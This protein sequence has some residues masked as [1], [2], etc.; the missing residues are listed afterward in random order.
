MRRSVIITVVSVA[1]LFC[2]TVTSF[3]AED[4]NPQ[5]PVRVELTL[6]EAINSALKNSFSIRQA[7]LDVDRAEKVRDAAWEYHG[8]MLTKTWVETEQAFVS[9]PGMD[10]MSLFQA[11]SADRAAHIQKKTFE[12][13]QDAI[14][15]QVTQA[16][17]DIHKKLEDLDTAR[18]ALESAERGYRV[19]KIKHEIGLATG[20]EVQGKKAELEGAKSGL[21]MAQAE[22]ENAYRKLNKLMGKDV[23]FRPELATPVEFEK[24][25]V[26]S[27]DAEITRAMNPN[28]NP[29]LWSKKEGY[30]LQRYVWTT[31]QP[32]EAGKIDIDKAKLSYEEA[33]VETRKTMNELYQLLKTLE[34]A[35]ESAVEA[36]AAAE[37]ALKTAQV[38]YENGMITGDDLLG[39]KIAVAKAEGDLLN[40]RIQYELVKINF[41]KP[42]LSFLG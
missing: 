4:Q 35:H 34:A 10:D 24:L 16:Y 36:L 26:P 7:E 40:V 3:A 1:I 27:L 11:L 9:I 23:N 17:Y 8:Y 30:E 22:L 21:E 37:Q 13:M 31:T 25:E 39:R 41:E 12:I 5:S 15:L 2:L 42:W 6:D 38:M 19:A 33:R 29:Y 32:A 14:K 28:Q 18:L 20:M